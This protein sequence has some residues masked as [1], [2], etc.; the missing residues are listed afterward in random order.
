MNA[1]LIILVIIFFVPVLSLAA[2]LITVWWIKRH[3]EKKEDK[4]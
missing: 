4:Q 3:L 1:C 2:D